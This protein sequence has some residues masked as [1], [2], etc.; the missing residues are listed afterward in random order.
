V[1]N[2]LVYG[3][4]TEQPWRPEDSFGARLALVRQYLG[5]W[6]VARTARRCGIDDQAWRNWEAG[7]NRPQDYPAVCRRISDALGADY[8]WL[9]IGGPLPPASTKWYLPSGLATVAA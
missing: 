3:V 6:N 2:A 7:R 4:V 9:M 5:G 8:V 1:D